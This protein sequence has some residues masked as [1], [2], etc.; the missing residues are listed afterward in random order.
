MIE[1][2]QWMDDAMAL[3]GFAL[4]TREMYLA[5]ASGLAKHY[6][7]FR[8]RLD[9]EQIQL[10]VAPDLM[11][12]AAHLD[13]GQNDDRGAVRNCAPADSH[14]VSWAATPSAGRF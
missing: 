6:H 3:R 1:L 2:R 9:A 14:S 13:D 8:D 7:C 11:K 12:A 4:R 5:C 10:P